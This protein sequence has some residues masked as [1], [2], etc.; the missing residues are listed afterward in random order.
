MGEGIDFAEWEKLFKEHGA[1]AK[2]SNKYGSYEASL[3]RS[4]VCDESKTKYFR[5]VGD[6][7]TTSFKA[8]C[9]G[10][11]M[12]KMGEMMGSP[13]FES[14]RKDMKMTDAP[15]M[16]LKPM[17]PSEP[18]PSLAAI[19]EVKDFDVWYAGFVEHATSTSVAGL[20][21]PVNRQQMCDDSKTEVFR[22]GNHVCMVMQGVRMDVIGQAMGD[23]EFIK[24]QDALGEI[25]E[26]KQM[27]VLEAMPPPPADA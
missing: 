10:V 3:P 27:Y 2:F 21:L 17:P 14:M 5:K 7:S 8:V 13:A 1:S 12:A 23:P 11:D 6:D 24:L 22:N 16:M 19:M 18:E 26:G 15:P 20:T 9:F 25:V 4:E